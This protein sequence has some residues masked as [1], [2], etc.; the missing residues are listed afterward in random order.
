MTFPDRLELPLRFDVARLRADLATLEAEEW[1][2]HFVAQ[3]YDG[4]WNVLALR[5]P[6]NAKHPILAIYPDPTA[7]DY[8]DTPALA[9]TPY[10]AQVLSALDCPLQAVRLMRLMPGSTIKEHCDHDLEMEAGKA[11]LHLPITT[12]PD[13]DF[14]LN[15]VRLAMAPGSLWYLRLSDRH[16]VVNGG[17]APRVHLV[18]DVLANG[19]L[20][21]LFV[22]ACTA[23]ASA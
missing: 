17:T 9:R 23:Q 21:D 7:T 16:S 15:G 22:R 10:F 8:A 2:P 6:A 5:G 11:R 20:T 1:T 14:R 19:W 18:I 13:V 3:N 4:D 12:N